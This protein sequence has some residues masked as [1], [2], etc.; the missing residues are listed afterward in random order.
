MN[1]VIRK[2]SV[3]TATNL[4]Q[5]VS[6]YGTLQV[7]PD[8]SPAIVLGGWH[9]SGWQNTTHHQV[10]MALL[11]EDASGIP[12]I[13]TNQYIN[14]PSTNG[15][16]A[17]VI[18]DFN[19]DGFDDIFLAAHN[20]SPLVEKASTVFLSTA[21]GTFSNVRLE[22][23]NMAH[24]SLLGMLDGVPTVVTSGYGET[25]PYY[26]FNTTTNQFEISYWGN[27]Y[28]GSLYGSSAIIWDMDSDGTEELLIGD[29]KTGPGYEF[30]PNQPTKFVL[31]EIENGS[32][33]NAPVFIGGLRFD[34]P[35]YQ[36]T[37]LV[38][39]FSGLSHNFRVW[40]DDFNHDGQPDVILGVGVWT[41]GS[42][43]WQKGQLQMFQ[44]KGQLAFLDVTDTL[45]QAYDENNPHID[46]SMQLM[47]IDN[48]GIKAYLLAGYEY[49]VSKQSSYIIL[50]DGTGQLHVALHDEFVSWG[51]GKFIPYLNRENGLDFL[52]LAGDK[53]LT[54]IE[55]NYKPATD[56]ITSINIADRNASKLIR[57]WAGDDTFSDVNLGAGSTKIDGGLGLD[58]ASYSLSF[59]NY[60][61]APQPEGGFRITGT[62]VDDTLINIER[63]EFAG[64]NV[65]LDTDGATSA[66][67][68]YRLYKAT[69]NREPDTGGLGY[70]IAQADAGTKDAVRMAEDF[71]W[72]EEF[73]NLYD[74][75]T[76][77]NYGTGTDVS[78]LVTGFYENV[79]G[80]SP[81]LGGLNYY[82]GV[83]ESREK[84]V[85]RVLAEISDS[86]ENYDGT[87]EL[88]AN[89]I[90]FD[91]WGA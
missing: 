78:E 82:T 17:F 47:D 28:S 42:K 46:Y 50:N 35:S 55:T 61:V 81:D 44:N 36:N 19:N 5:T 73:Q 89:G 87:I 75:T 11:V 91:P 48:S 32:L 66:G 77:D 65:A 88:I 45:N 74:I 8:K 27:T 80:R 58:V 29:F 12:R 26:Q 64:T 41:S 84:T 22:D 23:S 90:L 86:P 79:L 62:S 60:S 43:G 20:E 24:S 10:Q 71:T 34:A 40:V 56:F 51:L 18:K 3:G 15:T 1:E 68:I 59:S 53:S 39:D 33:G 13:V 25:D 2:V 72:S 9:Y 76:T 30:D 7:G 37:G 69:F 49:E 21:K 31:Y 52:L 38:S 85:G 14:D 16:G 83:I 70:W 57:T 54:A 67:G 63:L 4:N 6:F